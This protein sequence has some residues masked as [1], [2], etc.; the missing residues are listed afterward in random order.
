MNTVGQDCPKLKETT[1]HSR[2]YPLVD[3][4]QK[5]DEHV[6][7]IRFSLETQLN[8]SRIISMTITSKFEVS[9]HFWQSWP[10]VGHATPRPPLVPPALYADVEGHYATNFSFLSMFPT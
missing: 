6:E 9:L 3:K 4:Q 5:M 7:N 10:T 1:F 8:V 2:C